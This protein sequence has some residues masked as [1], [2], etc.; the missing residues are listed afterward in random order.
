[1]TARTLSSRSFRRSHPLVWGAVWLVA[2]FAARALLEGSTLAGWPRVAVAL[3]PIP[4]AALTLWGLVRAA[5]DLDEMQLRM[6][7]EALATAFLLS[8]LFL[9]TLGLLQRAVTLEFEDWS[10]AHVWGMLPLLY[11]IGLIGA[12]RRYE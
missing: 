1:M 5:R 8:I 10:Y 12:K 2:Y 9:M 11:V 6:Q 4:V 7:L 3:A